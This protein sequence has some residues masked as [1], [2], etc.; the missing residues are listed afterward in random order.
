MSGRRDADDLFID[1]RGQFVPLI[2]EVVYAARNTAENA[3]SGEVSR[4]LEDT[5]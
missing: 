2:D 5:L 4:N 3:A 1:G